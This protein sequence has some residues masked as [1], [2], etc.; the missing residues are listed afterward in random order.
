MGGHEKG[1]EEEARRKEGRE[2]EKLEE[3]SFELICERGGG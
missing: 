1:E 2:G 3:K